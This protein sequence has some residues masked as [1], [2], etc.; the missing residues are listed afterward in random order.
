MLPGGLFIVLVAFTG[1]KR[2]G[3]GTLRVIN[4][5]RTRRPLNVLVEWKAVTV[6]P[7][8]I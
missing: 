1:K 7:S 2:K 8:E 3:W 6:T 5:T 4:Y